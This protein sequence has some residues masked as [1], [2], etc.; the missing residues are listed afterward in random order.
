MIEIVEIDTGRE[1]DQEVDLDH[2]VGIDPIQ[3]EVDLEVDPIAQ[4]Q[5]TITTNTEKEIIQ[6]HI[7]TVIIIAMNQIML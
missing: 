5:A 7:L 4:I 2:I 1:V 6:C 3:E